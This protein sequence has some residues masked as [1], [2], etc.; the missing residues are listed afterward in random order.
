MRTNWLSALMGLAAVLRRRLRHA[1]ASALAAQ[2]RVATRVPMLACAALL[3]PCPNLL[4]APHPY[5]PPP[6]RPAQYSDWQRHAAYV[7]MRDGTRLA[8]TWY[9]P[10]KATDTGG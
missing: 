8:M 9:V 4:A 10:D 1:M 5:T 3:L 2:M 7:P 6:I